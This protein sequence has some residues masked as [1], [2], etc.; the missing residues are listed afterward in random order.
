M[1]IFILSALIFSVVQSRS[2]NRTLITEYG[3]ALI[4]Q[5]YIDE[6]TNAPSI[7]GKWYIA[8]YG[9]LKNEWRPQ[10]QIRICME[11]GRFNDSDKIRD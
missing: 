10:N 2:E 11:I 4:Y 8:S 6:E 7:E 1:I 3:Q 5:T 9:D